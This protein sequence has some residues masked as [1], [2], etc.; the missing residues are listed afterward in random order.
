MI[1]SSCLFE[2]HNGHALQTLQEAVLV[3]KK[4]MD[5]FGNLIIKACDVLRVE[6]EF[7]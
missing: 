7:A 1:C 2:T 6:S 5:E 3:V 4:Q